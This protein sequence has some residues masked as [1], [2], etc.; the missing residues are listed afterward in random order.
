[1]IQTLFLPGYLPERQNVL[2]RCH[3]SKRVKLVKE[4][5]DLVMAYSRDLTCATF[6][7]RVTVT[8]T[9]AGRRKERDP[10]SSHKLILD[11]LRAARLIVDDSPRWCELMP[12]V[13][14][15][16]DGIATTVELEDI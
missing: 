10:D 7:R 9:L 13:Q 14:V 5:N 2:M 1:M 12:L 6:K 8:L 16:G 15:R 3:W 11:G 4:C